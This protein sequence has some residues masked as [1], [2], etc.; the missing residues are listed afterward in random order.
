MLGTT[1][2]WNRAR[3]F[4]IAVSDDNQDLDIFVHHSA[5][6]K[7]IIRLIEGQ[8]IEFELGHREG[9]GPCALDVRILPESPNVAALAQAVVANG[10]A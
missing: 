4:G 2:R 8:R 6:P 3:G 9:K 10:N 7:G 5:L 1:L